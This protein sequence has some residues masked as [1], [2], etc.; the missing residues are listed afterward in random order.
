M[1]WFGGSWGGTEPRNS[2]WKKWIII[3]I[4]IKIHFELQDQIINQSFQFKN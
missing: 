2:M 3:M 1:I 4:T